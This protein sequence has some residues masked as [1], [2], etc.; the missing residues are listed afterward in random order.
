MLKSFY[1]NRVVY[2]L[3]GSSSL[4]FLLSYFYPFL[5]RIGEIVLLLVGVAL[6][7]DGLLLFGKT[8]G[9]R[10]K[11]IT[12]ERFSIGD[13]NKVILEVNNEYGFPVRI[14]II[15]EL[16]VQFQDR[17]W[18]KKTQLAPGEM[19]EIEYV[20]RPTSRGEYIFHDINVY[21]NGPLQLEH[22]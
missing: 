4:V 17:K 20:L 10:A 12:G 7:I 3:A 19:K 15:D 16:P 21:A 5:F 2:L 18:L 22:Q 14:S 8:A 9:I 13:A 6:L 11:R 1:L